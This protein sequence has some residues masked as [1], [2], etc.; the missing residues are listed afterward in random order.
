MC[1]SST[2]QATAELQF[3]RSSSIAWPVDDMPSNSG[4]PI[5]HL[6]LTVTA[7]TLSGAVIHTLVSRSVLTAITVSPCMPPYERPRALLLRT[8]TNA[9]HRLLPSLPSLRLR[10]CP[11][12][13]CSKDPVSLA[14]SPTARRK[15]LQAP[16]H[17]VAR[18]MPCFPPYLC[19]HAS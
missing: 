8:G 7:G 18:S 6:R 12:V 5:L 16:M 9:C 17:A 11:L 10:S 19:A 3:W 4:A 2:G 14:D 13:L 1:I 15:P